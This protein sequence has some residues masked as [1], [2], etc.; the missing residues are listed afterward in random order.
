MRGGNLKEGAFFRSASPCDDQHK[1]APY[2]NALAEQHG[3]RF[4]LN[5]S[6]NEKKYTAYTE[7]PAFASAY[8]DT[9]YKEGNVLLLAMNANYRSDAFA[10]TVSEAL[11]VMTEHEGYPRCRSR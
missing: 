9:L 2:A 11:F 6:D 3:I 5:L 7:D 1:R 8:Y 10:K 4:V